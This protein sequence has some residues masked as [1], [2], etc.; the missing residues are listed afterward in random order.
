MIN[1]ELKRCGISDICKLIL[2]PEKGLSTLPYLSKSILATSAT[3]ILVIVRITFRFKDSVQRLNF[4]MN[5]F[6]EFDLMQKKSFLDSLP[7]GKTLAGK[8]LDRREFLIKQL[9]GALLIAMGTAG[10]SFPKS[11][12]AGK[13]APVKTGI[14]DLGIVKG[15]PGPATRTAVELIGGMKSVIKPGNKVVIKPNM[16]YPLKPESA[17]NTHPEVLREI[18]AMSWEAGAS[19]IRVLDHP[20]AQNELCIQSIKQACEVF[21]K[22]IVHALTKFDFYKPAQIP[23]GLSLKKTDVMQ[24][25]LEADVLIAAPVAKSHS[26]TGVSLSMKG[27]MG[28][29]W[30]RMIMH[31]DHDLDSAIVDLCSL[32]RPQLVVI[33]ATRVLSDNGPNGPGKVIR[34]DTIVASKDMVTADAQTIQMCEW[35]GKR[36]EPSQIK[37]IRLAH[38]RGIGRMDIQNL[39]MKKITV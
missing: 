14:P 36:F 27:M 5:P 22:S 10:S 15:R 37:H 20:Y 17:T 29:I 38:Q 25:L 9:K 28:L 19:R 31:R 6:N 33:D 2:F 35:Y 8:P 13:P 32:L 39:S 12:L 24:D 16:S 34:M 11:V 26:A 1:Q 23:K 21:D 7:Y 30:D 3:L 4:L 18:V